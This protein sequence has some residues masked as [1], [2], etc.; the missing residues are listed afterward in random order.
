MCVLYNYKIYLY[1]I[2]SEHNRQVVAKIIKDLPSSKVKYT[3]DQ[4]RGKMIVL[5]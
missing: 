3:S 2:D 5:L 4:I 1:S